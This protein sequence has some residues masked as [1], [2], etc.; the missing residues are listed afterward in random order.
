[1]KNDNGPFAAEHKS[2]VYKAI[3]NRRDVRGQFLPTAIPDE[4]FSRVL[5]A[6]HHAPSVGFMQPWDFLV[7]QSQTVKQQIHAEFVKA[8]QH[9]ESLFEGKKRELYPALKLQGILEAPINLCITCDRERGGPVVLGKTAIP[10]MDLYST[11][12][13]VQNFWLAARAEGLGVGWVSIIDEQAMKDILGLPEHVVPIA[14][15]CVGYVS[16]FFEQPELQSKG[17]A[18]RLPLEELVSFDRF[19]QKKSAAESNLINQIEHDGK[20]YPYSLP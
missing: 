18:N 20:V 15:L 3:F 10:T 12:C 11:V 19:G 7:I 4:I 9:A 13:A 2:G 17:W 8:N 16:E 1:M 14:Y 5:Y 6:A